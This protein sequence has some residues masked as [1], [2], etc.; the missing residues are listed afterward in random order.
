M[1]VTA[2]A[3]FS[4]LSIL[5]NNTQVSDQQG[6]II[7]LDGGLNQIVE[8]LISVRSSA[9]KVMVIGNGGSAA[10]AN[11]MHNDLCKVIGVR[12]L[13]FYE[14]PMLTAFSNDH[15]YECVFERNIEL[16][17]KSKDLLIAISSSGNSENILRAVQASIERECWVV[18]L[19]GFQADNPLRKS[20]HYNIY[21][22]ANEYGFV[23]AAHSVITHL[24]TDAG[25][26]VRTSDQ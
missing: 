2:T 4:S 15:G 14:T 7:S 26:V 12:A 25:M 20:G 1:T 3:Y 21:T 22:P 5:L 17:A 18:T 16:W 13:T 23:E 8:L 24:I 6:S 10:I 9:G 11:H 19:S